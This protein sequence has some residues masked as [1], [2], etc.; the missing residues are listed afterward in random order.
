M[1]AVKPRMKPG[2]SLLYIFSYL[3]VIIWL[4][5][6]LWM[7]ITAIKPDGSPVTVLSSL[8]KPPFTMDNYKF[9]SENASIWR[10]TWNSVYIAFVTTGLTLLLTSMA[11]FA[12]S[13]IPFKGNKLVFWIIIAGLMVPTE[14]TIIPLFLMMVDNGLINSYSSIIFPSVAAPLGVLILKQFYDA[15]PKELVEAA[16]IDGASKL[17]IWWSI[18]LPLSRSS[19]AALGIFTF[20]SSWNN[21]L[22]PYLAISDEKMM[23]LPIGIPLFQSGY[24]A[25]LTIPMAANML[26]SLPAL[27]VFILFQ[28]H[29]IKGI[30][31][32]GI[33]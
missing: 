10:W 11:A 16:E 24:A 32:T 28:K 18:F 33:K 20:I 29:I 6:M 27:L 15:I 5:P 7:V 22:W 12:L 25:E 17:K 19:M 21:F 4:V 26:A 2:R 8:I 23:T 14:A 1:Q 13:R 30:T 9:V 3:L 31:M